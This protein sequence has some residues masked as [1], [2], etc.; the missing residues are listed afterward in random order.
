[1]PTA[2]T[3]TIIRGNTFVK[4][5]DPSPDG[6]R[7]NLL[8]GGFP[9]TGNGAQDRYEVY[10]NVF[11][12]NP[13]E[14]LFQASGRVT[15]HDNVFVDAPQTRALLLQD[16][17]LP[18]ELAYV[19]DNTLYDVATGIEFGN[20]AAQG[21]GVAG[22]LIF[23]ANPIT[24]PI[25]DEHDDMTDSVAHASVYVT[26]PSDT[27]SVMDFHPISGQCVGSAID[28]SK[29]SSDTDYG[30]DF[31]GTGRAPFVVRGAFEVHHASEPIDDDGAAPDA[32]ADGGTTSDGGASGCGCGVATSGSASWL[33]A[34]ALLIA[35]ARRS[36]KHWNP[37]I[38][39]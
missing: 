23:S 37:R 24:G 39:S 21:D 35:L 15:I 7:P 11:A 1:M 19:Y 38:R 14:S 30:I 17:D 2:P 29:F 36:A 27:R 26:S 12:H 25:Q 6:D 33:A 3:S 22:N 32:G 28:M 31:D 5:D 10:G 8:V 16:H 34:I 4:N 9:A 13:R 18:L 20:A